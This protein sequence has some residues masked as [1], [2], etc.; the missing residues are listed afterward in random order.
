[1]AANAPQELLFHVLHNYYDL[2]CKTFPARN[3]WQPFNN[4]GIVHDK[5]H[6]MCQE[7]YPL[8]ILVSE[9]L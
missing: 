5:D 2:D 6:I 9:E 3:S 7:E 4:K 1:M 8:S